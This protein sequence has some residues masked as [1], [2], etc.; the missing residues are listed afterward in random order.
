LL[1]GALARLPLE[2]RE[3]IVLHLKAD[4]KFKQ[5]ARMQG[6]SISTVQGRYRYGLSKLRT[7]LDGELKK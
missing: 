6:I 7:I 2:Q 1:A 5:I 4:M 3:T